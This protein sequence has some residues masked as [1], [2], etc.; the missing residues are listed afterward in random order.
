MPGPCPSSASVLGGGGRRGNTKQHPRGGRAAAAQPRCAGSAPPCPAEPPWGPR[1]DSATEGRGLA[2]GQAGSPAAQG[3]AETRGSAVAWT[4]CWAPSEIWRLKSRS[5]TSAP[6][7]HS[8]IVIGWARELSVP[9]GALDRC[10]HWRSTEPHTSAVEVVVAPGVRPTS[11]RTLPRVAQYPA[12]GIQTQTLPPQGA[13]RQG[14]S[15]Y[16]LSDP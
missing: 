3:L 9:P 11:P 4:D 14:W 6:L 16:C 5:T 12:T 13:Y 8:A 1:A 15:G 7:P 10:G 2:P